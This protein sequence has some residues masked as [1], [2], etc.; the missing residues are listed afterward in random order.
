MYSFPSK[1]IEYMASGTPV[2]MT[3]LKCLPKEYYQYLYFIDSE[4]PEGIRDKVIEFFNKTEDERVE[5]GLRASEFIL[6]NKTAPV[7]A[8]RIIDFIKNLN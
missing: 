7:Q 1:T 3:K 6:N 4:T 5:F 2:L 8:A